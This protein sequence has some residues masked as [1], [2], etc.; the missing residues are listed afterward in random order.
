MKEPIEE[1]FK[2]SLQGHEMPY[3]PD[4]WKAMSSKLDAV[5]P[6]AKPSSNLKYYFGAAGIGAVAIA[7]Y[8]IFT[9]GDT[10]MDTK[11]PV[12]QE[13]PL[14]KTSSEK[15]ESTSSKNEGTLGNS[16]GAS[17]SNETNGTV[18]GQSSDQ[19]SSG[20]NPSINTSNLNNTSSDGSTR[21]IIT[22]GVPEPT[23]TPQNDP[24]PNGQNPKDEST[25]AVSQKMKMPTVSDLCLNEETTITNQNNRE[26]YV[27][28]ALN[29]V[30]Q[31]I[32]ANKAIVFKPTKVGS[33]SLGYKNDGAMQFASG[34]VVNRIPDAHFTVDLINKYENGLPATHVQAIG[35]QGTYVWSAEGQSL[36]GDEGDLRF[37]NKGEQVITLTVDNGQCVT[38]AEKT[39]Y[40]EN[41]YNLMAVNGFTPTSSI[42]ENRTFIPYA[43]TQR[44]E[45]NFQM[46]IIDS[47]DGGIVYQTSDASLPWDGVDIRS[48]RRNENT[49]QVYVWKVV[50]LNPAPNEPSEYRG[51]VTMN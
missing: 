37:Y 11:D 40:V 10:T 21:T 26:I 33:Y 47:R 34:F 25:Q 48:G 16:T 29:N 39:I 35:G 17:N 6:V 15:T 27:L 24:N 43:L 8:F 31:T 2:Q 3:N 7:S 36:S 18:N 5:K 1:L 12:A 32:P 28:D 46:T 19:G 45:V 30:I 4:A 49:P 51:T 42:A 14:T 23:V 22:G 50:I 41:D 13:T 20:I 44:P 9:G 38:S